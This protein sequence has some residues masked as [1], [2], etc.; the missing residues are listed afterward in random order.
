MLIRLVGKVW[1]ELLQEKAGLIRHKFR[2]S[3]LSL[4][5]LKN[6]IKDIPDIEIRD[7]RLNTTGS[8]DK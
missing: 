1:Q 8:P 4:V 7:W 2:E 5:V 3:G 6:L